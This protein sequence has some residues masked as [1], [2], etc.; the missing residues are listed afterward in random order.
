MLTCAGVW[1]LWTVLSLVTLLAAALAWSLRTHQ[2][3][4]QAALSALAEATCPSCGFAFSLASANGAYEEHRVA[5]QAQLREALAAGYKLRLSSDWGFACPQCQAR[6]TYEAHASRSVRV[7]PDAV[8]N[9]KSHGQASR[10]VD[11]NSQ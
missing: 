3:E 1:A 4:H 7:T 2:R 9:Q 6:L 5:R 10:S 8:G 11:T